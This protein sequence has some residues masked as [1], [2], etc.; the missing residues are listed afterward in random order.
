M[1]EFFDYNLKVNTLHNITDRNF[2]HVIERIFI[3]ILNLY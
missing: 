3:A 1:T 2:Q